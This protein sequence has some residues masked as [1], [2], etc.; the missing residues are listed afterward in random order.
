MHQMRRLGHQAFALA[1]R[2]TDEVNLAVLQIAQ[3]TMNNAGGAA[4]CAGSKVMLL[5][6]QHAL[7]AADTFPRNGHAVDSSANDQNVKVASGERRAFTIC[8]LHRQL[9]LMK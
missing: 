3:S 1:Q 5:H 6:Q 4:G 7:P 8:S 9:T 2:F